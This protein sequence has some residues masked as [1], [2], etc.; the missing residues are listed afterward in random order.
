VCAYRVRKHIEAYAAVLNGLEAVIF[1]AGVGENNA[2][3]RRLACQDLDF[4]GIALDEAKNQ[5]RTPG[6]R[7]LS[8]PTC[9]TRILVVPTNEELKIARQCAELL[10]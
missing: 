3:V 7:D 2:L 5:T 4:F 10:K 9:R 8:Q 1:T 6:I